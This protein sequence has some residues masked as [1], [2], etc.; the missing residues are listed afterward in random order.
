MVLLSLD[1]KVEAIQHLDTLGREDPEDAKVWYQLARL[2]RS[3]GLHAFKQLGSL[4][5]D[6]VLV[7]ALKAE[8]YADAEKFQE[9]VKENK[10]V[11]RKKPDFPGV[12]YALGEIN[13]K[14][15]HI[16]QPHEELKL[17]LRE[18]PNHPMG[19]YYLG[20]VLL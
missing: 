17:A 11:Q 3:Q 16:P 4:D 5:P 6:S 19:N 18:D 9:A 7:H 8:S 20:E 1:R 13:Y 10:E 2:Y 14:P 12:H 15:A